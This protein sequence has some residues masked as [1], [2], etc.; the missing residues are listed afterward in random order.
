VD[1]R[2]LHIFAEQGYDYDPQVE[3]VTPGTTIAGYYQSPRYF[4]RIAMPL[5][6]WLTGA[7]LDA[8][9]QGYVHQAGSDPR[10]G[11][12]MRRG[13]YLSPEILPHLGLSEAGYFRR[14][15]AL[16]DRLHEGSQYLVYSDS[17]EMAQAELGTVAGLALAPDN[18]GLRSIAVLLAMATASGFIISNSTFGWWAAWLT[19]MSKPDVTV[20]APRPWN[21]RGD[22]ASDLLLP[23]WIT[24]DGR[25]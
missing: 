25:S 6:E 18:S 3:L 13:D 23:H 19:H 9:E 10:V 17:P 4:E 16:Y 5:Y 24:L 7:Q 2:R 20:I 11:V 8:V 21:R 1:G 12:H 15:V 22:S 14:A